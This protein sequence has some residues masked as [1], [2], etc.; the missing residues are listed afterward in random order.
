MLKKKFGYRRPFSYARPNLS[1]I[2]QL[3]QYRP[4][5]DAIIDALTIF[6]GI[7]PIVKR[8]DPEFSEKFTYE[9]NLY[10]EWKY[11]KIP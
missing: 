6:Y 11:L 3:A 2:I 7:S 4:G 5:R 8:Y 1:A 10:K 9:G